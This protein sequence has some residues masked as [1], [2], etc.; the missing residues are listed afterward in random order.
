MDRTADLLYRSALDSQCYAQENVQ[1]RAYHSSC[2]NESLTPWLHVPIIGPSIPLN[3]EDPRFIARYPLLFS[4][5]IFVRMKGLSKSGLNQLRDSIVIIYNTGKLQIF[6]PFLGQS[7]H[8]PILAL[9]RQFQHPM[10]LP[11]KNNSIPQPLQLVQVKFC[12]SPD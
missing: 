8:A 3:H 6:C 12:R 5:F 9:P 10:V 11:A 4:P 2:T 7:T 1:K